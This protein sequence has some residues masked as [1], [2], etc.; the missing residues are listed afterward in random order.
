M[1]HGFIRLSR[2]NS[3]I[4]DVSKLLALHYDAAD[5]QLANRINYHI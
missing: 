2:I 4:F 5:F 3:I 1:D